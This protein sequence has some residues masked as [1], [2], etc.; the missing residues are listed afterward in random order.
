M[1]DGL[2]VAHDSAAD[3]REFRRFV[4]DIQGQAALGNRTLLLLTSQSHREGSPEHTMVDGGIE[5]L[6]EMC[7]MRAVR[8]LVVRKQRG[9]AFM[10][11]RHQFRITENGL[12]V[13]PRLEALMNHKPTPSV[14]I[15]RVSTGITGFDKMIG[16]G[17]PAASATVLAGPSGSGKTTFGLQFLAQATPEAPGLLF[18]FYE[19]PARLLTKARSI[20]IDIDGLIASGALEIIWQS[21]AENLPDEL[22]RR[23]LTAISRRGVKR[24]FLDGI[25]ALRHAFLFPERLP[26]FVNALS[27]ALHESG[28][29]SVYSLE[30][31]QLFMPERM[32]MDDL[33]QMVD[34]VVL[35]HYARRANHIA[36]NMDRELLVLKIRDSGFDTFPEVFHI[37]DKGAQFG[38]GHTGGRRPDEAVSVGDGA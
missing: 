27:A 10:R 13:F 31:P 4:H 30:M 36:N 16:G 2:F 14:T 7:G 3:E 37:R 32:A 24:V 33:S 35:V 17:Y 12:E 15:D 1:L 21:P 28:T 26:L 23:M 34:N 20:G 6:D 8:N 9:G 18:G 11:G 25:G 5:F 29:T 22:A 38:Q 19:T